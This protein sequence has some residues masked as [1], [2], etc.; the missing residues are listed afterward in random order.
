MRSVVR[1]FFIFLCIFSLIAVFNPATSTA[2]KA[3]KKAKPEKAGAIKGS[4][5]ERYPKANAAFDINKMS[6]M[7]D[8]DPGKPVIPTGDTIKIAVVNAYSGASAYNGQLH[9]APISWAVHDINKRGGIMVDGKKK[10]IQLIKTDHMAKADQCKKICERMALQEKVHLFIGTSGSNMMKIIYDVGTKYKI[11]VWNYATMSDEMHD[12]HNFSRYTFMSSYSTEQVSRAMAYYFGQI[13][14]K[15]KKFYILNQDYAF[16]HDAA[17]AFKQGL[18]E[19]YPGAQIVG[20][21]YHKLFLTDFAPYLTKIKAS[22]AEIVYTNDWAPDSNNLKKQARQMNIN[23]PLAGNYVVVAG[24]VMAELGVEG[25]VG[26]IHIDQ[27]DMP[28]PFKNP[29]YVKFYK[30]WE[31]S[32]KKWQPP[33]NTILYRHGASGFLTSYC[34][35][36]YWLLSAVERAQSVDPEKLIKV[37]EGDTYQYVNG[38]IMKMRACDHKAIQD[39]SITQLVP[40]EQQKISYTI[41]PYYWA[42]EFAF[43]GRVDVVPA[44]KALPMMDQKLDRCKGKNGWGE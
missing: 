11:P 26:S 42:K 15:E 36:I 25:T 40:P 34:M 17:K 5:A 31:A 23:T 33:Y 41:P 43:T 13:R 1:S 10:L 21:D 35:Q 16:G 29:A 38:K 27:F 24:P 8:F 39:L 7:S 44:A 18:R 32:Y 12:S 28:N 9:F 4:V 20:E 19:Y 6:D 3:E 37:L 30:A 2:A 14:K 22:G